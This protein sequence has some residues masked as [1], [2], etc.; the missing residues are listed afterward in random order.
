MIRWG[1][2]RRVSRYAFAVIL[3]TLPMTARAQ[4]P[5]ARELVDRYVAEIGGRSAVLATS[6]WKATGTF[7]VAAAGLSGPLEVF[8]SDGKTFSRIT[9]PGI[10]ELLRGFDGA[11]GWSINPL[12]GPRILEGMELAQLTEESSRLATLRD[13]SV[14]TSMETLEKT[15]MNGEECWLVKVVWV[16]G[17]ETRDCFSIASGL[18]VANTGR[19]STTMGEFD[20]TTLINDYRQFGDVKIATRVTQRALGQEQVITTDSVEFAE[21]EASRFALPE[22]IRA[23]VGKG[24]G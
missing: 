19:T 3:A 7:S 1:N 13:K 14:V 22:S 6:S 5:A 9:V 21:V 16:S 18:I 4:T 10:G 15:T 2:P 12:E 23:L 11:T 17:R 20:Y 24:Q 8:Q